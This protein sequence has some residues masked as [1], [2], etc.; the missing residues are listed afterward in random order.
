MGV[1]HLQFFY[2]FTFNCLRS[3]KIQSLASHTNKNT[4]DDIFLLRLPPN[5]AITTLQLGS[6]IDTTSHDYILHS[7]R[8]ST[9]LGMTIVQHSIPPPY[10][11]LLIQ[12]V[13]LPKLFRGNGLVVNEKQMFQLQKFF[14]FVKIMKDVICNVAKLKI[15]LFFLGLVF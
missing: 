15:T 2:S 4:R 5:S 11:L 3:F 9:Q 7:Y 10:W 8:M 6:A 14:K 1:C 13:L 12:M